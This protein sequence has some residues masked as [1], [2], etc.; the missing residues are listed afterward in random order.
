LD[1]AL[2]AAD[3]GCHLMI[4]KPVSNSPEGLDLLRSVARERNLRIMIGFQFRFHPG[5]RLVKQ[6]LTN[7]TIGGVVSAH[8]HWGEYLPDWHPGEN[9]RRGYSAR[10][11]LGGGVLLTLCHPFDYLRWLL[12][13]VA[14]ISA[15]TSQLSGLELDVEDTADVTLR[16]AS[17]A[18]GTVH[19][20]YIQRPP[21][22]W[23]R[24]VGRE[25]SIEWDNGD[26]TVRV[27]RAAVEQWEQFVPPAGFARNSM[28]LD[29]MRH[30]IRCISGECEPAV[31]LED[32]TR[33]LMIAL[34]AKRSAT[35]GKIIEAM[36]V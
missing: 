26:G 14:A 21:S 24:I 8:A 33:A 12:G 6:L 13:E 28:F 5:L 2:P 25:G 30:F 18:V 3:A 17:G 23:L 22:H 32:G 27:Y 29:E 15:M 36:N 19:L 10:S 9:Y 4:E 31:S 1:I 20:D 11:D 35:E 34:G 16:F 7:G